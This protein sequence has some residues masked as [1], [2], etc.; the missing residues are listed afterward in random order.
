[1]NNFA[2]II[3]IATGILVIITLLYLSEILF[4]LGGI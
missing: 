4:K 2:D 1:M 3:N